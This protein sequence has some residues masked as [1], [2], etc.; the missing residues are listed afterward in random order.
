MLDVT[1]PVFHELHAKMLFRDPLGIVPRSAPFVI[2]SDA[3]RLPWT[4]AEHGELTGA[5]DGRLLAPLPAG[6]HVR[7]V[8]GPHGDE[9]YLIWTYENERHDYVW[10]PTFDPRIA[11]VLVRGVI[12]MIPGFGPYRDKH[13]GVV[14]GGYYCKTPENRPLVGPLG[15]TGAYVV[16]A[17]SGSG[18]MSSLA[19]GE[20][21]SLH[22]LGEA[23]PS[24]AR[25]F[26]PSRYDDPEY[27]AML[28]GWGPL[29]GQL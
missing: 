8:D 1:L 15:V 25:W 24:Y 9:L 4:A 16:G 7:P 12:R 18:L 19:C 29:V 27:V 10:P 2:W 3:E 20:L 21:V 13:D 23:L 6:V 17:L 22:L 28:K 14:D 5:G 26:N 11:M